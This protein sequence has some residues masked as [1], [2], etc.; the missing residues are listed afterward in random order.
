MTRFAR[1]LLAGLFLSTPAFAQI[2]PA[3]VTPIDGGGITTV[4]GISGA[5]TLA[6]GS[7]I[8]ITPSGS[9]FTFAASG[10]AAGFATNALTVSSFGGADYA[11]GS[12]TM[13]T[14]SATAPEVYVNGD[15]GV[16]N[17]YVSMRGTPTDSFVR[18][19]SDT[20]GVG[21]YL[22]SN[23]LTNQSSTMMS[24]GSGA[25]GAITFDG[26]AGSGTAFACLDS[27]GKLVRSATACAP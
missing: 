8:T 12:I 27:A 5:V 3:S 22:Y 25:G 21:T 13:D 11:H 1:L 6:A 15:N 26:L 19:F 14:T 10:V 7:N 17:S 16:N 24:W 20:S 9:T 4:N 2:R 23:R 18:V